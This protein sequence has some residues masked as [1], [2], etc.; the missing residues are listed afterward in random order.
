VEAVTLKPKHCGRYETAFAEIRRLL[1]PDAG[2]LSAFLKMTDAAEASRAIVSGT[3][4]GAAIDSAF[5]RIF[6]LKNLTAL[7]GEGATRNP[8][9]PFHE[10]FPAQLRAITARQAPA[11]NPWIWQIFSGKFPPGTPYDWL[12]ET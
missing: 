5:S 4:L 2:E 7:F 3:K 8:R 6:A 1:Q 12:L 9:R 10:H 11:E